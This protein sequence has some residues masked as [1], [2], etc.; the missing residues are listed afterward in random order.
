MNRGKRSVCLDVH[1]P[2]GKDVVFRLIDDADILLTNYRQSALERMGLGY[3]AVHA[4]NPRLI[5]AAVNG[6]GPVGPDSD[7]AMLDGAAQARGGLASMSGP[8][9]GPPMPAGATIADTAGA[10]QLA[11][12][13]MTALVARERSGVGQRVETSALGA[14]L[15][16]QMWEVLHSSMTGKA[17]RRSGSHLPTLLGPYGIY[18]TSDGNAFLFAVALDEASWDALWIFADMPEVAIDER[19]NTPIK[20]LGA[21]GSRVGL[22]AIRGKL[23]Q[24]FRSRSTPEWEEFLSTQPEIIYERV[25]GYDEVLEDPQVIANDY[26][27]TLDVPHVGPTR[28]VGNL[29]RMSETPGSVKGPPPTLGQHTEEVMKQAGFSEDEIREVCDHAAAMRAELMTSITG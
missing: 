7:K 26:L 9:D 12:G 19:W 1:T 27:A 10:M 8:E 4:R 25:R 16:L 14:Q 3:E 15:W 13:I 18:E 6:F 11:L 5:Y 2:L 17:L 24:A 28:M 21:A 29:V 22:E 23:R 20:R